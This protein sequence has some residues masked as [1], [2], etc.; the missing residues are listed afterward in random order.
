MEKFKQQ[1]KERENKDFIFGRKNE[2]SNVMYI[3]L[4]DKSIKIKAIQNANKLGVSLNTYILSAIRE[5]NLKTQ[6]EAAK[7][8]PEQ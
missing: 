2:E 1:L 5:K 7:A 3:R 6:D 8:L 4:P